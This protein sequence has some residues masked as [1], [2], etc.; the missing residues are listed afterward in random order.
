M[1]GSPSETRESEAPST[2]LRRR[3]PVV[4][5]AS[6]VGQEPCLLSRTF[7]ALATLLRWRRRR[8]PVFGVVSQRL[9]RSHRV[10]DSVARD[11]Q[12]VVMEARQHVAGNTSVR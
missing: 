7:L 5:D 3:A 10:V 6:S 11:E 2:Y 4:E 12:V 8:K 9:Q 1:V